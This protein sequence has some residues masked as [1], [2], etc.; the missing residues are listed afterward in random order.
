MCILVQCRV[1]VTEGAVGGAHA[2]SAVA[3]R[4]QNWT[5]ATPERRIERRVLVDLDDTSGHEVSHRSVL[6]DASW[7][8]ITA[9]RPRGGRPHRLASTVL[10]RAVW[11]LGLSGGT[12]YAELRGDGT[13][14]PPGQGAALATARLS[15]L[16]E[17]ECG[18]LLSTRGVGRL[19]FTSRNG[20]F[21]LPVN[22]DVT[23]G[24]LVFRTAPGSAAAAAAGHEA[25]RVD[26]AMS[27]G[28]SV[29]VVGRCRAFAVP[30]AAHRLDA[31]AHT[32][33]RAG[34]APPP[35]GRAQTRGRRPPSRGGAWAGGRRDLWVRVRPREVSGRVIR[36]ML[37]EEPPLRDPSAP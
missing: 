30:E 23:E 27:Q 12:T 29:L 34:G 16:D 2:G 13:D 10:T 5:W 22:H 3:P 31:A 4:T 7:G 20:P 36:P 9:D 1:R 11:S 21:V 25:D 14:R 35:R 33:P 26:D 18:A 15:V 17:E 32:A 6:H 24:E 37:A 19:A 8:V 28:W